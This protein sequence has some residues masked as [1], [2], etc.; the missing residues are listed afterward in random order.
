MKSKNNIIF[1]IVSVFL[2]SCVLFIVHTIPENE[3]LGTVYFFN[4][5]NEKLNYPHLF[6]KNYQTIRSFP[7]NPQF[8]NVENFI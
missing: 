8:F 7:P 4:G 6:I 1:L 5:K 3:V 2:L